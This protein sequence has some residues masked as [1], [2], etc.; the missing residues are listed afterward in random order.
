MRHTLSAIG[1]MILCAAGFVMSIYGSVQLNALKSPGFRELLHESSFWVAAIGGLM[2]A[3]AFE[4]MRRAQV[5]AAAPAQPVEAAEPVRSVEPTPTEPAKDERPAEDG[6]KLSLVE[7]VGLAAGGVI[8]SGWLLA[9]PGLHESLGEAALLGWAAGGVLMLTIA[10]VMVEFG[11]ISQRTG[12]LLFHPH[13]AFGPLVVIIL[14]ASLWISYAINPAAQAAA[15][16]NGLAEVVPALAGEGGLTG[17]GSA[18]A[19]AVTAAI[20]AFV[21]LPRRFVLRTNAALTLLKIAIPVIFV[22]FLVLAVPGRPTGAEPAPGP[23]ST[24]V[25]SAL[26][27][28]GVI[29]AYIGFQAPLDVTGEVRGGRREVARRVRWAVYGTVVGS[30]LLYSALQLVYAEHMSASG[31]EHGTSYARLTDAATLAGAPIDWL[32]VLIRI[33]AII[34]PIGSGIVFTYA[35]SRE[36]Y[37]LSAERYVPSGLH[38]PRAS[39]LPGRTSDSFWLILLVNLILALVVLVAVGGDWQTL[40]VLNTIPILILYAVTCVV[41]AVRSDL[42]GTGA[43]RLL[44]F[45]AYA[46]FVVIALVVNESAWDR[47]W[48]GVAV[49]G[50]G[51]LVLLVLPWLHHLRVP[52]LGWYDAKNHGA[53]L[54]S[55]DPANRPFVVL[56]LYLVAL[57]LLSAVRHR[58]DDDSVWSVWSLRALVMI[59]A[60]GA[61]V[62]LVGAGRRYLRQTRLTTIRP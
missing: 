32:V 37:A 58:I 8:G 12:G 21:L 59:V 50:W 33:A 7:V 24:G 23:T 20:I 35:L 2:T 57:T 5:P 48:K 41:L 38:E 1:R 61:F 27:T 31:A 10:V 52:G 36:V 47:V 30:F 16:V 53:R 40:A 55:R 45:A 25:L 17:V 49:I 19:V 26:I 62:L 42:L 4:A 51:S 13:D 22:V 39:R 34:A 54:V 46:A 43:Q 15:A 29:Y 28:S 11:L 56:A 9:V 44:P 18:L 60:S 3:I 14:A 6:D